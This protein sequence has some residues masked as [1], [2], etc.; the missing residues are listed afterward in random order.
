MVVAQIECISAV[1]I[2][3]LW[4]VCTLLAVLH[5]LYLFHYC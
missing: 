5:I 3:I 2:G 1:H 4:Y